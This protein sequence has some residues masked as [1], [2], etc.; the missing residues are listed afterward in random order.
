MSRYRDAWQHSDWDEAMAFWSDDILHHVPGHG[1]RSGMFTG[2]AS[3]LDHDIEVF[4]LLGGTIEVVG[5][6]DRLISDDHAVALV[7]ERA[8]RERGPS[9]S[10]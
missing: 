7:T 3:F 6:H 9:S 4:E 10:I 2:K 1:P 5:F 8:I